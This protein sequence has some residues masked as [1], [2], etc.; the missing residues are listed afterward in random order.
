MLNTDAMNAL[1]RSG[2]LSMVFGNHTLVPWFANEPDLSWDVAPLPQGVERVNV[3]GG[4][5]FVIGRRSQHKEAA[6][7]LVRY[8]TGPKAQAILSESGVIM[9]ARRSVRE[10]NIFL[11]QQPYHADVFL[12]ET[13]IGRPVPS[14]P[15]VTAMEQLIDESLAPLWRGEQGAAEVLRALQPRVEELIR[16]DGS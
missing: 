3:A 1:F 7:A 9:P 10:D 4:A 8:L 5:G 14:F 11:R 6:W 2:R 16:L 15:G 12:T 13:E